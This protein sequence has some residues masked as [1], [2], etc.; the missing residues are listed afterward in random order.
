MLAHDPFMVAA[1]FDAYWRMQRDID[2]RWRDRR[3]WW[4]MS[5]LNT[6]RTAWFSSDRTIGEYAADIWHVP[7]GQA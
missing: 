1:D 6:A 3:S 4:R 2:A 7:V 5:L